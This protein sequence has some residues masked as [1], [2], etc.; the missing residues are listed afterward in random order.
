MR[1]GP[2]WAAPRRAGVRGALAAPVLL[3]A[4]VAGCMPPPAEPEPAIAAVEASPAQDNKPIIEIDKSRRIAVPSADGIDPSVAHAGISRYFEACSMFLLDAAGVA[5][6]TGIPVGTMESGNGGTCIL[7][8]AG[9]GSVDAVTVEAVALERPADSVL[10]GGADVVD[11]T[12]ACSD[13]VR[14]APPAPPVPAGPDAGNPAPPED[15]EARES[16]D[17]IPVPPADAWARGNAYVDCVATPRHDGRGLEVRTTV[18]VGNNLWSVA[19]VRPRH[20]ANKGD[21]AEH[22][23]RLHALVDRMMTATG[24]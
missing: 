6:V 2:T 20:S 24:R 17:G 7:L 8:A 10:R 18:A 22:T 11:A 14:P 4:S 19:I 23:A 3:L 13:V 21:A 1:R 12:L 5:A 15:G 16:D 9:P